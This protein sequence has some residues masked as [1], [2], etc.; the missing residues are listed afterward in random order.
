MKWIDYR[1]VKPPCG[2]TVLVQVRDIA[3]STDRYYY[4]NDFASYECGSKMWKL[5][6]KIAFT[7][8]ISS[9]YDDTHIRY[10]MLIPEAIKYQKD[11]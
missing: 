11:E 10:W 3:P 4:Y 5:F 9:S 6:K 7:G 1:E 8:S 2:V